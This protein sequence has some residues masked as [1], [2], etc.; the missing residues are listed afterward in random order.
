MSDGKISNCSH[1]ADVAEDLLYA[2][3]SFFDWRTL[4]QFSFADKYFQTLLR[5]PRANHAWQHA[6]K[7]FHVGTWPSTILSYETIGGLS[8][9][10]MAR[11]AILTRCHGC[12]NSNDTIVCWGFNARFCRKCLVKLTAGEFFLQRDFK[13]DSQELIGLPYIK[14]H[15]AHSY[16]GGDHTRYIMAHVAKRIGHPLGEHHRHRLRGE[17]ERRAIKNRLLT[18]LCFRLKCKRSGLTRLSSIKQIIAELTEGK[19]DTLASCCAALN[20]RGL[21]AEIENHTWF[22]PNEREKKARS[23]KE[24]LNENANSGK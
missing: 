15:V 9:W 14:L 7:T 16:S 19:I 5:G 12:H 8:F 10:D 6:M 24:F 22:D 4:F 17:S 2:I 3:L 21:V 23:V 13:I 20:Q 1:I 11:L 18:L